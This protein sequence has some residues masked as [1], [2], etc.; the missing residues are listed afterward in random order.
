MSWINILINGKDGSDLKGYGRVS[1]RRRK[2]IATAT[3]PP[4]K[5]SEMTIDSVKLSRRRK[6]K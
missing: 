4:V 2:E 1:L 6:T 3:F 5:P